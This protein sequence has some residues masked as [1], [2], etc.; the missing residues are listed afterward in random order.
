MLIKY[1][2]SFLGLH[3][4][5]MEVPRLGVK[6]ELQPQAYTTATATPDLN[7]ICNLHHNVLPFQFCEISPHSL[8]Q[9]QILNS[10]RGA[11]DRTHLLMDTSQVLNLLSPDGN[12]LNYFFFF[13]P[14]R[15]TPTAY[16]GSQARGPVGAVAAS[17]RHSHSNAGSK[18]CLQPRT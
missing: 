8:Q 6:S 13:C 9:H 12:Y 11:K 7:H 14:F 4:W 5:R 1:I 18:P 15:A 17:L 10:L 3:R 2:Y 16:G